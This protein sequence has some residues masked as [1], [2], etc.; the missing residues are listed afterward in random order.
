MMLHEAKMAPV[1]LDLF[2]RQRLKTH[3]RFLPPSFSVRLHKVL[4]H[5][6]PTYVAFSADLIKQ[7]VAVQDTLLDALLQVRREGVQL[8]SPDLMLPWRRADWAIEDGSYRFAVMSS[9]ACDLADR[10]TSA[11][12][13]LDHESIPDGGSSGKERCGWGGQATAGG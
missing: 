4:D 6:L 3:G 8:P 13:V 12:Q 2:A 1:H 5:A 9:D 7:L 11:V 10:H